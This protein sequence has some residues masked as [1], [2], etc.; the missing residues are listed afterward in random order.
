[1]AVRDLSFPSA[2]GRDQIQ[3]WVCEPVRPPRA[4][5]QIVHGLGEHSRCYD[6]LVTRLLDEGFV[7]AADDHAGHGRTAVVSGVWADTGDNGAAAVVAD[8]LTLHGLVSDLFPGLPWILFGHSWGSMIARVVAAEHCEDLSAL[9]LC[10]I[11]AQCHWLERG[12]DRA[13]L[14]AR[15]AAGRGETHDSALGAQMREEFN[16][17]IPEDDRGSW[18]SVSPDVV[19]EHANDPLKRGTAMTLRFLQDFITVYDR[20]NSPE[21]S[22]GVRRDLPVLIVAGDA[23]PVANYGEGAYHVANQLAASGHHDVHTRV[24]PGYRHEIFIEPDI[25]DEV[26]DEIAGFINA[27]LS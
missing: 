11:A 8:E 13:D 5:V 18:V 17:R 2:N 3:A 15:I 23:D 22:T 9:A 6:H 25:H 20:A 1:M 10:G 12:V 21:F 7:V 4:I 26:E 16:S 27:H 19:R 14:G 24:W